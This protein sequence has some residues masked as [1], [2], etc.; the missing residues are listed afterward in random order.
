MTDKEMKGKYMKDG[1]KTPIL[2][3]LCIPNA[4]LSQNPKY[5]Y[6]QKKDGVCQRF[7]NYNFH[8]PWILAMLAGADETF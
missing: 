3:L 6:T 4:R 2:R 8:H 5:K 7:I 1:S